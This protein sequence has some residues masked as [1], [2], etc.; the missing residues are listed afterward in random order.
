[1][2]TAQ[3]KEVA[4]VLL[5]FLLVGPCVLMFMSRLFVTCA[6]VYAYASAYAL[7]KTSLYAC[8][9]S[10]NRTVGNVVIVTQR[11]PPCV[12]VSDT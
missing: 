5:M 6:Y 12:F 8:V 4:F 10:E 9:P 11:A 2:K 7:V 3:D 1:M